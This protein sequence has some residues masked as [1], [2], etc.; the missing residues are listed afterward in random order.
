[1]LKLSQMRDVAVYAPKRGKEG[2]AGAYQRVGKI[3]TTVFS[4]QGDRVVGFLVHRPDVVGMVRRP[5][6]FLSIDAMAP[7]DGGVRA[8]KGD[9]SFDDAARARLGIDWDRCLI[10]SGMDAKTTDGKVLGY[11]DDATFNTKTG[12]VECFYVGDGSV[13]KKLVG[14][15]EI[16]ASLLR[17]YDAG[18]MLV[19]PSAARGNLTGGV[20]GRA[21]EGYARA[22]VEGKKVAEMVGKRAGEAASTGSHALGKQLGRTKGMFGSFMDEY[23][24]ASRGE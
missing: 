20:V 14:T 9:D 12:E 16:P 22:K 1:M 5:E 2:A 19:D 13:A 15:V 21:G 6:L 10:W 11:V 4:P 3:R 23:R 8:T 7:C 18:Y 17:G 24:K